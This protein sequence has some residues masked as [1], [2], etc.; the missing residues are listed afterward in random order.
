MSSLTS[1][2]KLVTAIRT[3]AADADESAAFG[4]VVEVALREISGSDF[5]GIAEST[6]GVTRTRA[7]SDPRVEQLDQA[8]YELKEGPCITAAVADADVVVSDDLATD[9]R[10]PRFG[11][12]AVALGV[13][14]AISFRL[15]DDQ[16]T[17]GS[18]N[19]YAWKP[20]AFGADAQ[21]VGVLLAA[22]AAVVLAA[23]CKQANLSVALETRDAV[24]QAKGIL[25]ERYKVDD[26]QAF[27]VLIAVSQHT[28]RKLR[29]VADD[30]RTTG[31]LPELG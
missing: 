7:A 25:M 8:Q 6:R 10:W 13:N 2:S 11:Q 1:P 23:S 28:H 15:F 21:E 26:R 27:D 17:I 3:M 12:A 16:E 24:G 5:G 14:S 30:L 9:H 4:R 20:Q 19:I 31:E 29:D 22:H 18:L